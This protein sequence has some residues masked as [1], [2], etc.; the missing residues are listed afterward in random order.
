MLSQKLHFARPYALAVYS[1]AAE[2]KTIDKWL[3]F[4]N[5]LDLL[6]QDKSITG[7]I[8]TPQVSMEAKTSLIIEALK[9]NDN[10]FKIFVSLLINSKKM[11]LSSFIKTLL[12][13]YRNDNLEIVNLT[14][15][16]V[17]EA[18]ASQKK[19]IEDAL[20]RLYKGKEIKVDYKIDEKMTAGI[21]IMYMDKLIDLSLSNLIKNF[22]TNLV[23]P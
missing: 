12:E 6:L 8:A 16:S 2:H 20:S 23:S 4:L 19:M 17:F 15:F 13:D 9:L 11:S 22:N 3:E 1:Y 5:N 10:S 14:V 18:N 21:K 7:I